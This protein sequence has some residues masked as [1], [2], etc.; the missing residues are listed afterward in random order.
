METWKRI[1]GYSLYE[2][3]DLGRLKTFNWKNKG[4]EAIM[5]PA[6]D[7]HGYLRTMLKRDGTGKFDTIKVH[8]IIGITFIPNPEN[9]PQ[10][11][12][13]NGIR[14]D[15]RAI[16]LEWMTQSENIKDSFTQGR[17]SNKGEGNPAATLTNEQVIEIRKNYVYGRKNLRKGE[18][19]KKDIAE[20]YGTTFSIIKHITQGRTWKHLL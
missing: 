17:S 20:K 14:S 2:A 3:S 12:H 13:K 7:G 18:L 16:N 1:P 9:K 19:S 6:L 8:R 4:I 11:N 10:I 5:K 15:D